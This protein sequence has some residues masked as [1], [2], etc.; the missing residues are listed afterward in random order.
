MANEAQYSANNPPP[1][2]VT[3]V[4]T[5]TGAVVLDKT[6]IGLGNVANVAQ[7]SASNPP[8]YPVTSV[9]GS[10][11][12]VT[13]NVPSAATATPSDL[14]TAAVGTSSKYAKEDH[15]HK[16][17]TA[18]D[19]G[20][21]PSSTSI[22]SKTSD[23]TNDSGFITSA[24]IPAAATETPENLGTA[25]VGTSTKYAREDHVHTKPTYS[26]SDVG[27]GNVDNVKQYSADNPPPYP[28]TSVNGSTGDVT[29]SIP[30]ASST[31]PSDLGTAAVGTGTTWARSD[32]VHKMPSASDVGALPDST[33]IPSK[34]SDLTNDSGFITGMTI[35]SYG[36]STWSDF[37]TA[38]NANKVVYCRASSNSNPASGSQTRMA[39]LAYVNNQTTPT[40]A[41]FQY[42]RSVATHSDSQ[43]GDQVYVYKINSS[44]T[45]SVTVRE[46]YTKVIAGT[47]L[48]SSYSSGA[49]TLSS[50]I[51]AATATPSDL[52]TAAVGTSTKYAREDHVHTKPTYSKSDVG[53]DNVD[54]VQQ[55]SASN[56]PPYPVTSVNGK[57]GAVTVAEDDQTWNGV[58]LVKEQIISTGDGTY[59]PLATSTSPTTMSF[60]PVRKTPLQNAIAKYDANS[61]LYS[62]T[63]STGDN[64]TKVATTAYVDAATPAAATATPADLGT[65]AVGSS[66]KYAKEDHVH[67]YPDVVYIGSSAPSD[68]NI[69]LWL[70]NTSGGGSVVTSVNGASGSVN[71]PTVAIQD[72][73]PTGGELL[74][75]DTDELGTQITVPQI[76]DTTTS[77]VDT[78]SSQKI[79]N[80]LNTV[81]IESTTVDTTY[82]GVTTTDGCVLRKSGNIVQCEIAFGDGTTFSNLTGTD[83]ICF[84]PEGYRPLINTFVIFAARDNGTWASANYAIAIAR[85]EADSGSVTVRQ[86][87]SVM[88]TMKYVTGGMTWIT[89]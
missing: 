33:S 24:D 42:Y 32:H 57:T 61:Y 68:T 36:S 66:S 82:G 49:I 31:T 70:D 54:N 46:A 44:G 23:L 14:G 26:K 5:K 45:W 7:Y 62:T 56:P 41:E 3:S 53:L 25:A 40:E 15:V 89:E 51:E 43:Q 2:P 13:V 4:N 10:T 22:P 34:T 74:W 55:Y 87:T 83:R 64:S 50:S 69:E 52:G 67:N 6:D 58:S 72:S 78:W 80:M 85:I 21:L 30:S 81:V 28:V 76:D 65:A 75:V 86:N 48:S 18:S 11:G 73:T 19:V 29:I 8:P 16:M 38:Y 79:N 1:Y 60:T 27:L 77:S 20:A 84:I 71:V 37:L 17:P 63:P 9:N 59:V 47:G 35:L 88:S 12:A 39:F